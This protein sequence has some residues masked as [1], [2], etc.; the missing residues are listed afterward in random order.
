MLPAACIVP[1]TSASPAWVDP[2]VP[3]FSPLV[4]LCPVPE[5]VPVEPG[6]LQLMQEKRLLS[7]CPPL[8]QEE[9]KRLVHLAGLLSGADA[10][11]H[12]EQLK[13][14]IL[15]NLGNSE[16]QEK[17]MLLRQQL[18]AGTQGAAAAPTSSA[19]N[20]WQERLLLLL[21]D[22]AERAEEVL[23][24][25]LSRIGKQHQDLFA[26]LEEENDDGVRFDD[27]QLQ[28][29]THAQNS[30]QP[31]RIQAWATMLAQ[32]SLP[33]QN[34]WY[35]TRQESL[36]AQVQ[37]QYQRAM[38]QLSLHLPELLL[39]MCYQKELCTDPLLERCPGLLEA[40]T[41]LQTL[42]RGGAVTQNTHNQP[43]EKAIALFA[44]Q[45]PLWN[46]MIRTT[47][48]E[49]SAFY[50]LQLT[51]LPGISFP[52]LLA[53]VFAAGRDTQNTAPSPVDG[54]AALCLFG[55]LSPPDN[56]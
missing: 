4:H 50:R 5:S 11:Q 14:L 6:L 21:A 51:I 52:R 17:T 35:I 56:D 45:V 37:E 46:G 10:A 3:V 42:A 48:S 25:E 39:P 53:G 24:A 49:Q 7:L 23:A 18:R 34:I 31:K 38:R 30:W 54:G 12:S 36:A 9:A 41:R 15:E 33:R 43:L 2:L 8:P 27:A 1:E 55:L 40:F 20:L 44:E 13:Q 19:D 16:N 22:Q 29:S 28:A 47:R 26:A 32:V